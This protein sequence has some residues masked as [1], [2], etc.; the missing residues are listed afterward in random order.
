[1]LLTN[2]GMLYPSLFYKANAGKYVST[3]SERESSG[4]KKIIWKKS[5]KSIIFMVT[6]ILFLHANHLKFTSHPNLVNG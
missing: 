3:E 1:M 6:G 5:K 4:T 2:I